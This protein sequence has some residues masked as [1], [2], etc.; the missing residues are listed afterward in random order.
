MQ[1]TI[2]SNKGEGL[3]SNVGRRYHQVGPEAI[4]FPKR[5]LIVHGLKYY[6]N[7]CDFWMN[8]TRFCAESASEGDD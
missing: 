8:L 3:Y 1:V 5:T 6:E 2:H 4:P 7:L